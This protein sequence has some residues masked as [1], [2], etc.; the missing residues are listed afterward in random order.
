MDKCPVS[1]RSAP[2]PGALLAPAHWPAW[3]AVAVGRLLAALPW[4]VQ[5]PLG[6]VI[7]AL[8]QRLASHRTTTARINLDLCLPELT[9]HQR[10]NL[11]A[12]VFRQA[13]IGLLETLNAWF[14]A[15]DFYAGRVSVSGL[16]HLEQARADGKGVLLIGAH[17]STLDLG[18]LLVAPLATVDMIYR[19]QAHPVLEWLLIRGRTRFQGRMIEYRDMRSL[20]NALRQGRIVWYPADQDAGRKHTVFAPFFGVPATTLTTPARW[21]GSLGCRIVMIHFRRL[22]NEERY[23]VAF[24][25]GPEHCGDPVEDATRL[26]QALESLIRREPAQY[27]WYHRRFKTRPPGEASPYPV[28]DVSH[29]QRRRK[30]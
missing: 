6:S 3:G 1:P 22:G 4:S 7:G 15:P 5:R 19:P 25:P 14:R 17:Y 13:G 30:A 12:D 27:M 16:E 28:R 10:Q 26:N 18:A 2:L 21:V 20:M 9:A 11:L 24:E 29:R 8:L 23:E